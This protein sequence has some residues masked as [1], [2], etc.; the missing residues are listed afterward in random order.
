[1]NMMSD[2]PISVVI[3]L[4]NKER[5]IASALESI[6]DQS[7]QP[8]EIIV[9]NDGSTD[10]ST[11]VV[12][13]FNDPRIKLINQEHSGVSAARNTGWRMAQSEWVAFL[14][15]D[16]E[17]KTDFLL[18]TSTMVRALAK[19]G[20]VVVGSSH[21][22]ENGQPWVDDA[23]PS[24]LIED[25][26]GASA[27]IRRSLLHG[28]AVLVKK[29]ALMEIGGFPEGIQFGEDN[30]TWCRLAWTGPIGFIK[31]PLVVRNLQAE[32]NTARLP[33][34]VGPEYPVPLQSFRRWKREGRISSHLLKS[35][36]KYIADNT[37]YYLRQ[38]LGRNTGKLTYLRLLVKF[39]PVC[40]HRPS[41]FKAL[42]TDSLS[43][44]SID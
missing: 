14:D 8:A 43:K 23:S 3:P 28:S 33:Y 7:Y 24:G 42:L 21:M 40:L 26:F 36:R 19:E 5:Y 30:D 27:A 1:M 15:G 34:P 13:L 9:V 6:L 4:Y 25:Y 31:E 41:G 29:Q 35:S 10:R 17:W 18:K 37:L 22:D 39:A 38:V 11:E 2:L 12:E 20:V 16:D 44:R 32:G